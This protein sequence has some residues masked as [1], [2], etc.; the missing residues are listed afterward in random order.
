MSKVFYE[1]KKLVFTPVINTSKQLFFEMKE[2][3]DGKEYYSNFWT[4]KS[5][6]SYNYMLISSY[7]GRAY[8]NFREYMDIGKEYCVLGDSG[9]YQKVTLEVDFSALSVLEWQEKNVDAGFVLDRPPFENS[10]SKF[11]GKGNDYNLFVSSMEETEKNS[12]IMLVN[13]SKD[14]KL[15]GII[16]GNSPSQ[17][18]EWYEKMEKIQDE[19]GKKFDGW[20][21]SPKPSND[22]Y[23]VTLYS[24]LA[25]M[26]EEREQKTKP[27][28][29][30]QVSG[31]DSLVVLSF[32]SKMYDGFITT[33]SSTSFLAMRYG[34][35]ISPFSLK[36]KIDLGKKRGLN[37]S[38]FPCNCPVCSKFEFNPK[39]LTKGDYRFLTLHNLFQIINFIDFCSALAEDRERYVNEMKDYVVD[40][41]NVKETVKILDYC[42]DYG[43]EKC[44]KVYEKALSKN[45]TLLK[46]KKLTLY[47]SFG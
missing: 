46:E 38:K 15:Y 12:K 45:S 4:K 25:K 1:E 24:I 32:F 9:G 39:E 16:Q 37:I 31:S 43:W 20:A 8:P 17:V 11:F 35:V 21:F 5:P 2:G 26:I 33:D 34:Q 18:I 10:G 3:V 14:F 42:L 29:F 6:F 30:L 7:Y 47:S 41:E 28:H 22:T 19:T 36:H 40:K 13:K 44:F 23:K 27:I